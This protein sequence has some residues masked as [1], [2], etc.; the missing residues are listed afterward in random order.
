MG[1]GTSFKSH[2]SKSSRELYMYMCWRHVA[3]IYCWLKYLGASKNQTKFSSSAITSGWETCWMRTGDLLSICFSLNHKF[4]S[5]WS[6][7][8][9]YHSIKSHTYSQLQICEQKYCQQFQTFELEDLI[10]RLCYR[11]FFADKISN[12]NTSMFC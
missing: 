3:C 9:G 5:T 6:L 12:V 8:K 10:D 1:V 7:G 2:N 4:D 11:V